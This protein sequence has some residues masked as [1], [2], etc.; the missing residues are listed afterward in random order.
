MKINVKNNS[1]GNTQKIEILKNFLRFCQLNSPLKSDINVVFVNRTTETFFDGNYLVPTKFSKL[2]E[3]IEKISKFWIEEFS[4][5]RRINCVGIESELLVKFFME[6]NPN[7]S[8][9]INV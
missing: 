3:G 4:K 5:Q 2:G 6:Q 1:T 9:M 7:I 8:K